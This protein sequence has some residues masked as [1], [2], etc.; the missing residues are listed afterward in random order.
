MPILK[1][2]VPQS[3]VKD[4]RDSG[5]VFFEAKCDYCGTIFYPARRTAMYCSK[6]CNMEHK[7]LAHAAGMKAVDAFLGN[8]SKREK[9]KP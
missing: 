3:K 2:V 9:A 5:H 1:K 7:N 6:R 8:R 4:Y